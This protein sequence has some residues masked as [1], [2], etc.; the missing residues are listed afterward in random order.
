MAK[1]TLTRQLEGD[2]ERDQT[3]QKGTRERPE[4]DGAMA[5]GLTQINDVASKS[6][7]NGASWTEGQK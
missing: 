3:D 6:Q 1:H 5:D 4:R 2:R 7:H